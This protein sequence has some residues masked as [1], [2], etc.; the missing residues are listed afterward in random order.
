VE[1]AATDAAMLGIQEGDLVRVES[2][3]GWIDVPARI[4]AIR[5]GVV[6]TPFHYGYF[7]DPSGSP[8]GAPHAA[9]EL[10]LTEWDPVSKQPYFK[11]GAVR[12][13]KLADGGGAPSP[14]PTIGGAAPLIASSSVPPTSGGQM[15]EAISTV[16]GS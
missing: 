8:A 10:T 12:V 3:R 5:Q 11:A 16:E 9:N 1:L 4:T 15:A 7:D 13:V 2:R 6:F 14:A